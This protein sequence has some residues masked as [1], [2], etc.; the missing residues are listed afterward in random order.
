MSKYRKK[1]III[2]AW[3]FKANSLMPSWISDDRRITFPSAFEIAISTLEGIMIAH[4]EDWI[5][6]GV[7]GELYPCNRD[8]FAMTYEQVK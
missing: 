3:Q 2:E 7:K 8:I 4:P 1:T 5:I 6:K